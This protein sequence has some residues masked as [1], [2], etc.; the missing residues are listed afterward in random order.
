MGID[1]DAWDYFFLGFGF[2]LDFLTGF[3]FTGLGFFTDFLE[4]VEL[5]AVPSN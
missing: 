4:P 2:G 1:G 5:E 3:L